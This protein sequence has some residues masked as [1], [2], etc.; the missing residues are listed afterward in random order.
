[1]YTF[2]DFKD[3]AGDV[4]DILG[5]RRDVAGD[6]V[7]ILGRRRDVAGDV[8]DILTFYRIKALTRIFNL[9]LPYSALLYPPNT[10][11]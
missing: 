5:R 3:V 11:C 10:P 7:D 4:V 2:N 9:K 1:L 8:V 6:V